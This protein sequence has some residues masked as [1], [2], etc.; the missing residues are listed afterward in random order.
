MTLAL[1]CPIPGAPAD[2]GMVPSVVTFH[3][4]RDWCSRRCGDGS[5]LFRV[6]GD[7]APA[8][9]GMVQAA[10][11]PCRRG[12]SVLPQTRGWFARGAVAIDPSDGAPAD[13]GMVLA[14]WLRRPRGWVR[15]HKPRRS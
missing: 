3:I 11:G 14:Q 2:A 7:G 10:P 6:A 9:A 1:L 4:A 13:V 5:C 8:D 12:Y 15:K